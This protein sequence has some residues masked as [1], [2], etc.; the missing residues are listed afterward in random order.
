MYISSPGGAKGLK[1]LACLKY[2]IAWKHEIRLTLGLNAAE[3]TDY[4]KKTSK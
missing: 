3:N 1:R 2:Y 4:M